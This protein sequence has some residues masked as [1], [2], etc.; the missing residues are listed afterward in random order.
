M[1]ADMYPD[2]ALAPG[3]SPRSALTEYLNAHSEFE[4]DK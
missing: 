2:R 1:H 3:N 4:I